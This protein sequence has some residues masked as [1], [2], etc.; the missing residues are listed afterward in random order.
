MNPGW[1]MGLNTP[2]TANIFGSILFAAALC[3]FGA[4]TLMAAAKTRP[5]GASVSAFLA[6]AC[7][8]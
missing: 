8:G 6:K 3:K 7:P 5:T 4:W 1:M 2:L